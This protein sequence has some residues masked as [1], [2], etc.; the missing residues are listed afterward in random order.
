MRIIIQ[1][2]L[3]F[4]TSHITAGALAHHPWIDELEN[5]HHHT[6][7]LQEKKQKK[8]SSW[9]FIDLKEVCLH[10]ST[11]PCNFSVTCLNYLSSI[12]ELSHY[13]LQNHS[14]LKLFQVS[15][16]TKPK[17]KTL[18]FF[19]E[20]RIIKIQKRIK[21]RK[22]EISHAHNSIRNRILLSIKNIF[23]AIS[24]IQKNTPKDITAELHTSFSDEVLPQ[25]KILKHHLKTL[26]NQIT[27]ELNITEK[28][29][30]KKSEFR[31]QKNIEIIEDL[32]YF[33]KKNP[34]LD[35]HY[36]KSIEYLKSSFHEHT[37]IKN[38]TN[39]LSFIRFIKIHHSINCDIQ[40][41][42]F[43]TKFKKKFPHL[44]FLKKTQ[45]KH[46]QS[47]NDIEKITSSA[48]QNEQET[49]QDVI[50]IYNNK[51]K[52]YAHLITTSKSSTNEFSFLKKEIEI[53]L[54]ENPEHT[55]K[56]SL[57]DYLYT[58]K[59]IQRIHSHI[60]LFNDLV[61]LEN[62]SSFL[63]SKQ[64]LI[65]SLQN[66]YQHDLEKKT[67]E[68]DLL[69]ALR[70]SHWIIAT[71][72][73]HFDLIKALQKNS[74]SQSLG[75]KHPHFI[76]IINQI[77]QDLSHMI[78]KNH[79]HIIMSKTQH[80]RREFIFSLQKTHDIASAI[81]QKTG[82]AIDTLSRITTQLNELTSWEKNI[83]KPPQS[84]IHHMGHGLPNLGVT[85]YINSVLQVIFHSSLQHLISENHVLND[86]SPTLPCLNKR[87]SFQLSLR[88]IY[89]A[90]LKPK[91]DQ[92]LT[93]QL[94]N[95]FIIHLSDL[96]GVPY[97][98]FIREQQDVNEL[99]QN[100]LFWIESDSF[101]HQYDGLNN[102]PILPL[103][104]KHFDLED[105]IPSTFHSSGPINIFQIS[106]SQWT[107]YR[108]QKFKDSIEKK[109]VL[110]KSNYPKKLSA[111]IIHR[112]NIASSGH[113]IAIIHHKNSV[114]IYND[115]H[116]SIHTH[117][118]FKNHF[119]HEWEKNHTTLIYS[120][121]K[122][123]L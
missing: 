34:L 96:T 33:I 104:C 103:D 113:Y 91:Y 10:S 56:E 80:M 13:A 43:K 100:I 28:E 123:D 74:T 93:H 83:E 99:L 111:S 37:Y 29:K 22:K 51:D 48:Y 52:P 31:H 35:A 98:D 72:Q 42:S 66:L 106:R 46:T 47:L 97:N 59:K 108:V 94:L 41:I 110:T 5:K 38:K 26:Q 30:N 24:Y 112:G 19:F 119:L 40:K 55:Q 107:G 12:D 84:H 49:M 50:E 75:S 64:S 68:E 53:L 78:D 58:G 90:L 8:V 45:N 63:N 109:D 54:H 115:D 76:S 32:Y 71:P 16:K 77:L 11:Q 1:L 4:M 44:S 60:A 85:C 17:M 62:D 69:D 3:F 39:L 121:D 2:S 88:N 117:D 87:K 20:H 122:G 114:S 70:S 23:P 101:F 7:C 21:Q 95:K 9:S 27:S 82:Y 120:H 15:L 14:E 61:F 89:F 105:N 65:E 25:T 79:T 6:F 73:N 67:H 116:V 36:K 92:E 57:D 81:S 18:E 118:E 86:I 102:H